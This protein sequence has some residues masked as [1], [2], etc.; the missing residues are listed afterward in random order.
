ME[1]NWQLEEYQQKQYLHDKL[2]VLK[3]YDGKDGEHEHC[4]LCWDRFSL[5]PTDAHKGYF[6]E[7]SKSWICEECFQ[8][9][10]KLFGWKLKTP[11]S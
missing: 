3:L 9:F 10:R 7:E 4:E 2:L 1:K 5:D 11:K 6:E 8:D